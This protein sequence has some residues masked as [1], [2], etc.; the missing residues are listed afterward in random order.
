[1]SLGTMVPGSEID[2]DWRAILIGAAVV[3]V[4]CSLP[5]LGGW[6]EMPNAAGAQEFGGTVQEEEGPGIGATLVPFLI[7]APGP[8]VAGS[9]ARTNNLEGAVEGLLSVPLGGVVPVIGALVQE[10]LALGSMSIA[11]K[12]EFLWRGVG[13][14]AVLGVLFVP[15]ACGLGAALGWIGQLTRDVLN[16]GIKIAWS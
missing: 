15:I 11:W 6:I 9:L 14:H 13:F 3:G 1:M 2:P 4:L 16:G 10:F 7:G 5:V 8:F 12:V